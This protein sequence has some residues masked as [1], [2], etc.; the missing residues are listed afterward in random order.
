MQFQLFA[1]EK[2]VVKKDKPIVVY[3]T[4]NW[5]ENEFGRWYILDNENNYFPFVGKY[6][7]AHKLA[8]N[9]KDWLK[10]R[11]VHEIEVQKE[12]LKEYMEWLEYFIFFPLPEEANCIL[13]YNNNIEVK[14][15]RTFL[16]NNKQIYY[17]LS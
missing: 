16:V 17:G 4:N 5:K 1:K 9:H 7:N 13:V 11:I 8:M 6:R 2:K 10:V 14:D 3:E 12:N 15:T